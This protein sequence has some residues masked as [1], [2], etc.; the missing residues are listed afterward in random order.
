MSWLYTVVFAGLIFSSHA[1]SV[2]NTEYAA[3][4]HP[5]IAESA[6]RDESE[7]FEHVYP[8]SASGRLSLSNVN[9]SVIIEA[10][11]RNEVKVEYTKTSD[12]KERLADVDVRID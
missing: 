11:D 12:S 1:N 7:H 6:M 9:G 8:L 3:Q 5:L 4:N 2:S 10:W